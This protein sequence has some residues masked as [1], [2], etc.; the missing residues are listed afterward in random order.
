[1]TV[2]TGRTRAVQQEADGAS[3]GV[4]LTSAEPDARRPG[5]WNRGLL[6]A[7]LR[8][9][10]PPRW[11]QELIVILVCYEIYSAIRNLVPSHEHLALRRAH[12]LYRFERRVGLAWEKGANHW[13]NHHGWLAVACN[14]YY[15]TMHFIVTIAVLVWL[16]VWRPRYY[17][18]VRVSLAVATVVALFG[19]WL[20]A[21][22]P[23]RMLH[24]VGF[25]DTIVKYHTWGSWGSNDMNSISNQF[26]AMPSLH[27]AWSSWCGITLWKLARQQW[28]RVLGVVYPFVTLFVIISTAN[29]FVMDAVGGAVVLT[30][31]YLV[32]RVAL[33]RPAYAPAPLSVSAST[34]GSGPRAKAARADQ[35]AEA[36]DAQEAAEAARTASAGQPADEPGATD[37]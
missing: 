20:Y 19:F 11:W 24:D 4:P 21:L 8:A 34:R 27:F 12:A 9:H 32:Q 16:Y 35:A 6:P 14:Y 15:A 22:A 13:L 31:G 10:K 3:A 29:H 17:R 28:L 7:R 26:A 30:V 36:A 23:P 2:S 25:V 1:M 37:S 5:F 18:A 33:G